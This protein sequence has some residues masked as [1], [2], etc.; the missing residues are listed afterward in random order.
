MS[1]QDPYKVLGLKP[2]ASKDEIKSKYRELVKKYHPDKYSDNPL[3]DL[4]EEKMREVNEAYDALM[5]GGGTGNGFGDSNNS[6]YS[7]GGT[8]AQSAAIRRDINSG[9][10]FAAESKLNSI[11]NR[12]AE[13][14]FLY[15]AINMRKGMMNEA[16]QGLSMATQMN[17]NNM[18]YRSA[19]AQLQAQSNAYS[20]NAYNRG[21]NNND[22]QCCQICAAMACLDCMCDAC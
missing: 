3:G 18:E 20:Q 17:P 13:W 5:N 9:N 1:N 12:D 22:N 14:W 8:N 11:S 21:Y 4:A 10:V 19:F 15:G 16:Y 7:S 6:S 2:G